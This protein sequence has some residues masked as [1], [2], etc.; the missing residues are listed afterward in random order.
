MKNIENGMVLY[1]EPK[2][3]VP[4]CPVCGKECETYYFDRYGDIIGC[5]E[6]ITYGDAI[7]Y[8]SE[9]DDESVGF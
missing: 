8:Q 9:E 1:T 3:V 5:D 4:I 6:C 2:Q 7:E